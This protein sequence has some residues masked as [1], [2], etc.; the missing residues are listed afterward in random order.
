MPI[1]DYY[2]PHLLA[3]LWFVVCWAGYTRYAQAK[4]RT[5]PCLASVLHLYREDWM[6]R[7]LLRENRIADANVI[8]NLER[9]AS[10][11]AS[12]TLIILAGVLTVLGASD[13]ALS[14]LADIP[15]VQQATRGMSEVK[16]LCL[17]MV[18]VYAFFT[19]SWCMRQYNFAA[20]LVGS[21]PMIGERHVTEQE[22]KAFAERTARVIS[23]AANQ[24]NQGLRAYYFGMATLAWFINP[25]F[26]MLV[27]A[28][29]VLILY[30][31][32]FHSDVL[33]VMVYTQ[34]PA[35]DPPKEKS[36]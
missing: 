21:A 12:S 33:E 25:W 19:F 11:F 3:V 29:V 8:G 5:T 14:L 20:V 24:F 1:S 36:E 18:F 26:F 22:R 17:G 9:N 31:R 34:T 16:L 30:H 15:F 6:R 32:E 4:G 27:S 2:L 23:M 35:F 10:F 7:M 28:G 13:R